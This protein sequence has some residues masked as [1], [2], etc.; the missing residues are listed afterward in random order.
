MHAKGEVL[1]VSVNHAVHVR[2]GGEWRQLKLVPGATLLKAAPAAMKAAAAPDLPRP[3]GSPVGAVYDQPRSDGLYAAR[4]VSGWKVI[5]F[6]GDRTVIRASTMPEETLPNVLK[7]L[8]P[9][10]EDVPAPLELT[11]DRVRW[12]SDHAVTYDGTW[13]GERLELEVV[14]SSSAGWRG[15]LLLGGGPH[16]QAREVARTA[17]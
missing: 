11:G 6:L 12:T 9:G 2:V 14:S 10:K 5:R 17:C 1:V 8:T 15:G 16:G 7:W 3:S 13:S 4:D